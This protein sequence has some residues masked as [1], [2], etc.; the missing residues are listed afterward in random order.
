MN[1]G[2]GTVRAMLLAAKARREALE[3]KAPDVAGQT[4]TKKTV[5][6]DGAVSARASGKASVPVLRRE[7]I[8]QVEPEDIA[9]APPSQVL[10]DP[11]AYRRR[12][13]QHRAAFW[14]RFGV[15]R[16]NGS[17][18]EMKP[19]KMPDP[20]ALLLL[21]REQAIVSDEQ[22]DAAWRV[23]SESKLWRAARQTD[24]QDSEA[25]SAKSGSPESVVRQ[26]A[27]RS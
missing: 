15:N 8:R 24:E 6:A 17:F 18:Y 3:G 16:R 26:L 10:A 9:G 19:H 12:R 7:R 21:L 27:S 5:T 11:G 4:K 1:M 2:Q 23:V 20:V 14:L 13:L 22:L 25:E